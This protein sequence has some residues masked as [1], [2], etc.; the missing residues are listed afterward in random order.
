MKIEITD[1]YKALGIPYPD[2]ETMCKGKCEGIGLY[3]T[4]KK[5]LNK[6]ACEANGGRLTIVGQKE[7]D[8]T[9]TEEDD[10]VFVQCPDCYGTGKRNTSEIPMGKI[11]HN[12]QL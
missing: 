10:W 9:P 1:R 2:R 11:N 12:N 8:G 3:P 6:E 5:D 4:E 7:K